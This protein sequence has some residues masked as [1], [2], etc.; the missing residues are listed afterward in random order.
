MLPRGV[1]NNHH[2]AEKT[3][4]SRVGNKGGTGRLMLTCR[5]SRCF[6]EGPGVLHETAWLGGGV[7]RRGVSGE[8]WLEVGPVVRGDAWRNK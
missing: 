2:K 6:G 7:T 8:G 1:R 5:S 4:E 3:G